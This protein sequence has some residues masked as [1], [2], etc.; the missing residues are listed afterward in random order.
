MQT[1]S[2]KDA[3][4]FAIKLEESGRNFY[5][6]CGEKA[7]KE[8][9]RKAFMFL[10]AEEKKH[11]STFKRMQEM[12][13][14]GGGASVTGEHARL[15]LEAYAESFFP[16]EALAGEKPLKRLTTIEALGFAMK[17]ELHSIHYYK[18]LRSVVPED[19]RDSIDEILHEEELHR[20]KLSH[21]RDSLQGSKK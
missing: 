7:R 18:R 19:E 4:G 21:L 20:S 11:L 5:T 16:G 10:A 13:Q 1:L 8:G 6:S 9:A 12:A 3:F 17:M 14:V 15:L 2:L